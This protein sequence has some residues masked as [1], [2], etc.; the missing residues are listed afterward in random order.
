M[1]TSNISHSEKD[2]PLFA[3]NGSQRTLTKGFLPLDNFCLELIYIMYLVL[4]HGVPSQKC[5]RASIV[6]MWKHQCS[7]LIYLHHVF[8][9]ER[10]LLQLQIFMVRFTSHTSALAFQKV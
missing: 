10:D 6:Q 3:N 2:I 5:S 9:Y 8:R 4:S 7:L 1:N